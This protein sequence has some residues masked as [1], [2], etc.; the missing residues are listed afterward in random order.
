MPTVKTVNLNFF[1][2]EVTALY[3]KVHIY[4]PAVIRPMSDSM[5]LSKLLDS[6]GQKSIFQNWNLV[7]DPNREMETKVTLNTDAYK[8]DGKVLKTKD[9][10]TDVANLADIF[11]ADGSLITPADDAAAQKQQKALDAIA[12]AYGY[13]RIY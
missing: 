3:C 7:I 4:S 6:T 1:D 9:G 12:K 10:T 13:R 5:E 2:A 8:W 11:K